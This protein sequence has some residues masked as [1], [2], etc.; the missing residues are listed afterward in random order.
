MRNNSLI[1][2]TGVS[3]FSII[4]FYS[5]LIALTI[6]TDGKTDRESNTLAARGLEEL[7]VRGFI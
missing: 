4:L 5:T 6:L 7:R 1:F 2:R 3:C